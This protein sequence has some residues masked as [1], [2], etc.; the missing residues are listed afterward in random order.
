MFLFVC[1]KTYLNNTFKYSSMWFKKGPRQRILSIEIHDE[2]IDNDISKLI[3]EVEKQI[4]SLQESLN[5]KDF[6]AKDII[7]KDLV[8]SFMK[9]ME[10]TDLLIQDVYDIRGIELEQKGYI[11]IKD[12]SYLTDKLK[13]LTVIKQNL[14]SLTEMF[15]QNPSGKELE[16]DIMK[17]LYKDLD[18]IIAG[19]NKIKTDD[20]F[21]KKQYEQMVKVA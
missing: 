21:L 9:I 14:T 4:K 15:N 8:K 5:R 13:Q 19:L 3:L 7:D 16:A 2:K 20:R 12:T 17:D 10:K 6:T 18:K 11:T 1:T